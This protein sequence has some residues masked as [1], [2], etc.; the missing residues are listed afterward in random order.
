MI[1]RMKDIWGKL[2]KEV[3]ICIMFV[4]VVL[5]HGLVYAFIVPMGQVPD[6][7]AHY[8]MIEQEFGTTGYVE[9]LNSG[10]F[11]AGGYEAVKWHPDVKVNPEAVA[12]IA[13]AR[14]SKPLYL[15]DFHP[16]YMI[17]RHL[18]AGLGFYLGIA[19]GLPMLT[20]T[21]LAEIFSVLFFV[22]IG[23]LTIRTAPVKKEIFAFCMLIPVTLQQCA[24]VSYDAV[25]IPLAFLLFAYVLRLY[26]QDRPIRWKQ[27][28][29][30]A[31]LALVLLIAKMPYVL[32]ALTLLIIPASR[33]ELKIGKRIEIAHLIRKYWYIVLLF[34]AALIGL[35][36]YLFRENSLVKTM[37]ADVLSLG[38]FIRMLGRTF[39]QNA[40]EYYYMLIG[41]FG[42]LESRV[43]AFFVVI[44]TGVLVWL[45]ASRT[46]KPS[47][48]IN[49]GRRLWLLFVFA[50]VSLVSLI[51]LQEW[52]YQFFGA[53]TTGGIEVFRAHINNLDYIVG[54]QGRYITPVLPVLLV[55]TSGIINR[56]NKKTCWFVQ[57]AYYTYAF[58]M[59][60]HV[61]QARYWG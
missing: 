43:S 2:N 6:E 23:L 55:A 18:P 48:E 10:V 31:G 39:K 37:L 50:L 9:E 36:F 59:V 29:C 42:W 28:F 33:F 27:I 60:Y 40:Y 15:S 11:A 1:A 20:C 26:E 4:I 61:L 54:F 17:L 8:E 47:R 58:I 22:G 52:T 56:K 24:S 44:F 38:D 34:L 5:A 3:L 49:A 21:Y 12:S 7:M 30:V 45:N 25:L 14:F 46:E 41:V 19:F 51:G 53:N 57:V 13:S 32:M 16:S 35:G